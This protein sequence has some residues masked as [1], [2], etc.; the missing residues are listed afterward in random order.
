MRKLLFLIPLLVLLGIN[1]MAEN[2]QTERVVLKLIDAVRALPPDTEFI[3]NGRSHTKEEAAD[4]L[5]LKYNRAKKRIKSPEDFIEHI[6]S[7]SYLSGKEYLI[8]F[9][10]NITVSSGVFFRQELKKTEGL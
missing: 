9:S 8:R 4:H 7:R 6:A 1:V 10:D 5:L 3:R 2:N